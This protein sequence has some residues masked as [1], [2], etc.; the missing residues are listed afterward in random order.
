[1]AD[2]GQSNTID[3]TLTEA[4]L[5]RSRVIISLSWFGAQDMSLFSVSDDSAAPLTWIIDAAGTDEPSTSGRWA[6]LISAGAPVGLPAGTTITIVLE[7]TGSGLATNRVAVVTSWEG[8]DFSDSG[9]LA[10]VGTQDEGSG[11]FWGTPF[12]VALP[13]GAAYIAIAHEDAAGA[14]SNSSTFPVIEIADVDGGGNNDVA[15]VYRD[16]GDG[17]SDKSVAGTWS[18]SVANTM[19]AYAVYLPYSGPPPQ[20]GLADGDI[21][22]T[23]F[24]GVEAWSI[25]PT[26]GQSTLTEALLSKPTVLTS[27]TDRHIEVTYVGAGTV[28]VEALIEV[29]PLEPP[30]EGPHILRCWHVNPVDGDCQ[31]W[32]GATLIAG[33]GLLP[34]ASDHNTTWH[35]QEHV[36]TPEEV[37]LISDYSILNFRLYQADD[38]GSATGVGAISYVEFIIP[39]IAPTTPQ[40]AL[41]VAVV[42]AGSWTAV[43]AASIY[44]AIDEATAGSDDT[45]Y[46][47][48][49]VATSGG[50]EFK[51]RVAPITDP[52]T[53]T[54]HIVRYR[55]LK[56]GTL[57]DTINLIVN[58]YRADGTTLVATTT[59]TNIVA[60]TTGSFTLTGGEADSIPTGDYATGLVLGFKEV[61]T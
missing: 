55:Y 44:E 13:V 30:V 6:G 27:F 40:V 22:N 5:A 21:S 7:E 20:I 41:P 29:S 61:K 35:I 26:A 42:S 3:V 48:S 28:F 17:A 19:V 24:G 12:A 52:S 14:V 39:E 9:Y 56:N 8:M 43:G 53:D 32:Q 2:I 46:A 16:D 50:H 15:V 51:V 33:F 38:G 59:I 4:A 34:V 25:H 36:L 31:I 18:T 23:G 10:E 37:A 1:M 60:I 49:P 57:G 58:L 45:D 11:S 54:G 47:E